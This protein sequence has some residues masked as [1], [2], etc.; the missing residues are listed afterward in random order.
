MTDLEKQI[1]EFKTMAITLGK[2]AEK[3]M[4]KFQG[5][6]NVLTPEQR[7]KVDKELEKDKNIEK[8]QQMWN[9]LNFN[10]L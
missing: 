4:N 9:D 6:R 3:A 2:D 1:K 7:K 5:I 8:A 10:D